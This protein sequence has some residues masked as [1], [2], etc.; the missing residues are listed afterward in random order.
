MDAASYYGADRNKAITMAS[1][2]KDLFELVP[3]SQAIMKLAL[4]S[5]MGQ[6]ILVIYNMADTF[7][8]GLTG[9]DAK[10]TSV[11]VC[12]PAFM[13]LSAI[14]NLFGIGGGAAFARA[15][16][17]GKKERAQNI[18]THALYGTV[19][20]TVCYCILA[21]IFRDWFIDVLGGIH[22]DVHIL[23]VEYLRI[24]VIIGGLGTSLNTLFSHLIRAEG[25]SI[26]ASA[27]IMMGGVLNMV[28]DPLFM[29][30]IFPA[31]KEVAG[32][33]AATAL[34][35]FIACMY[36]AVLLTVL[37]KKESQLRFHLSADGFTDGTAREILLTGLPAC[38][39]TLF[40]NI[41][42]AVLDR[43]MA[44]HG[45]AAQAGIGVAKKINMLAHSVVRGVSQGVLP[46]FAYS[47]AARNYQRMKE[48]LKV[49]EMISVTLSLVTMIL[50]LIFAEELVGVFITSGTESLQYGAV[51][52]RILCIGC[53]FSAF[54]YTFISFF[55]AVRQSRISFALAV[56]RK[57][58]LDIPLM[59]LLGALIP[60]YGIVLATPAADAVCC[61]CASMLGGRWL[62]SIK[63]V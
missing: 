9:S 29:F 3:V 40:E 55:Q 61:L 42:Y 22:A 57:G 31:G 52:L 45:M 2:K 13:F 37:R 18:S 51:F 43:Q 63:E 30:V 35:N 53:P 50:F 27:G 49:T 62:A 26:E 23:S 41:S 16:G 44:N 60:I 21:W 6:I 12:M 19:F 36:Y 4:P 46:L 7:F 17:A 1:E 48:A 8:I 34:A 58:A 20:T 33:A 28:L 10:L 14:S 5:V 32:A 56:L 11:T 25:R 59:F 24:T 39:M 47:Y 15:L 38:L 54:A